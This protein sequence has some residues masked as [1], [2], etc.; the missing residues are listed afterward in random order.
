MKKTKRT[1]W[2]HTAIG[3]LLMFLIASLPPFHSAVTQTG[4]KVLGVFIGTLYLWMTVGSLWPSLFSIAILGF[5]GFGTEEGTIASGMSR[6][7]SSFLGNST[8]ML[9]LF[10]MI[11]SAALEVYGITDW[12][13]HRIL[14]LSLLKGHPWRLIATILSASFLMGAFIN[15]FTP[16]L[17]FWPI[18]DEIF[19]QIG[20]RKEEAED[21]TLPKMMTVLIVA[22]A[23]IG[24]AVPPYMGTPLVLIS[25]F[26]TLSGGKET[27]STVSY[28]VTT[29]LCGCLM[30]I[31]MLAVSRLI[32]RPDVSKLMNYQADT[33]EEP[34]DFRQRTLLISFAVMIVFMLVPAMLPQTDS[35]IKA[36]TSASSGLPLLFV[37]IMAM[38]PCKDGPVL[39]VQKV[40]SR[41]FN[42]STYFLCGAA[43]EL[44]SAL[45]DSS[46]GLS[47]CLQDVLSPVFMNVSP[48]V[49]PVIVILVCVLLTNFC[50]S[51]VVAMI[52][53][54]IIV[55]YCSLKGIP[56]APLNT[57][58]MMAALMP[59]LCTPAA[60]PFAAMLHAN[61]TWLQKKDIYRM[62]ALYVIAETAVLLTAGYFLSYLLN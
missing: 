26:A 8:M 31:V 27:I 12:M 32:I 52:M 17:L 23:V 2:I 59:A 34:L 9:I 48:F 56:G 19:V 6:V 55:T 4:M 3:I 61:T 58:T 54:P 35:V 50:N 51:L 30:L 10:I 1:T 16:I 47:A 38:I 40:I 13:A 62:T 22:A 14:G 44:G 24:Y 20:Y 15:P 60:S 29:F 46:T 45:T 7:I 42:W 39:D 28:L 43:I 37:A 33:K 53:E 49:F 57:I 11:F 41:N 25:N 5:S 21:A 36:L 18:M